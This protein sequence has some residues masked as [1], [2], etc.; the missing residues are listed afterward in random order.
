MNRFYNSYV[1]LKLSDLYFSR[2]RDLIMI[3]FKCRL[4]LSVC[5][6]YFVIIK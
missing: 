4:V 1:Q 6:L 2:S 5:I 3:F